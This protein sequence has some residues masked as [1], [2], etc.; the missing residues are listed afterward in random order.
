MSVTDLQAYR[1]AK[2]DAQ[3]RA[4]AAFQGYVAALERA[5][6]NPVLPNMIEA[7]R[8]FDTFMRVWGMSDAERRE[9]LG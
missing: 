6:A 3:A 9:I 2:D 1:A 7:V 4:E 5:Q 8:A